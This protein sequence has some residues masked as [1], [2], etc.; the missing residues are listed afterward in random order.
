MYLYLIRHGETDWNVEERAQGQIDI[1]LNA[2]GLEQAKQLAARFASNGK[3]FQALYSSP[4]QR[5]QVTANAIAEATGLLM[6]VD[7]RLAEVNVG[8][9]EGMT[10]KEVNA[11]YPEFIA[12]MRSNNQRVHWP[13]QED[14]ADFIARVSSFAND[15]RAR[16]Q[17]SENVIVVS[18]GATLGLYLMLLLGL[19]P[20][21]RSPFIFDNASLT[22]VHL[23]EPVH[24]LLRLNDVCHLQ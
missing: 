23:R 4:L 10:S 3:T 12:Q 1:P 24:R 6:I 9:I 17:E 18:H 8:A 5:A 2:R 21:L 19:D 15:L 7:A 22:L 14:R 13:G 20:H 16:H 11:K